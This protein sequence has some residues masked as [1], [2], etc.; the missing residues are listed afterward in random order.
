MLNSLLWFNFQLSFAIYYQYVFFLCC[1]TGFSVPCANVV[2]LLW[3]FFE[4]CCCLLAETE[5]LYCKLST[6]KL[7]RGASPSQGVLSDPRLG[8]TDRKMECETCT[9]NMAEC[10]GH[11]DHLELAKPMFRLGFMKTVLHHANCCFKLFPDSG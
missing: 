3:N 10:P 6:A 9:A 1:R 7:Q 11:F 8:L 4:S 5:C 2:K